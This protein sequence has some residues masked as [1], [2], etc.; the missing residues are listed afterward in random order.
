MG[1]TIL[2][3]KGYSGYGAIGLWCTPDHPIMIKSGDTLKKKDPKEGFYDVSCL[4]AATM[5]I[6]RE[7]LE[8]CNCDP[9]YTI[10]FVDWDF[11]MTMTSKGYKLGLLCDDRFRP[12]NDVGGRDKK[13]KEGRSDKKT[14]DNS[15]QRF[16]DKWNI[17][18]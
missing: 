18:I 14:I 11:S 9:L 13:Y 16:M 10:G 3:Q 17:K 4:G 7:V 5:T 8:T 15:K 2:D 12:T 1:S 6:R